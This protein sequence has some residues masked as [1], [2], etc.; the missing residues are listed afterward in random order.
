[1][2]G[3]KCNETIPE[4]TPSPKNDKRR[5]TDFELVLHNRGIRNLILYGVCTDICVR[6]TTREAEDRG[7][8]CVLVEYAWCATIEEQ[9]S[10]V[11]MTRTEG[12]IFGA[13]CLRRMLLLY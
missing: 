11:E 7:D 8:D 5:V 3:R 2:R 13:T 10:S 12:G 1:M 6:A 9:V 4:L